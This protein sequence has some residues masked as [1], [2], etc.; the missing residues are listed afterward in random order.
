V[1][2]AAAPKLFFPCAECGT[3]LKARPDLAGKKI[4]CARCGKAVLVPS[5]AG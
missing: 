5:L 3:K 2:L 4:K 1:P